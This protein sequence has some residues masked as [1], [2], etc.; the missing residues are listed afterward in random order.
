MTTMRRGWLHLAAGAGFGRVFG[1]F[2]N[3]LLSRWLGPIDLGLFNL[4]TTTVQNTDTLVRL[5]ADYA[6]NFELG[7]KSEATLTRRFAQL[8][9]AFVQ[10]CSLMTVVLC[11]GAAI[12]VL[13]AQGLFPNPS[14]NNHRLILG[15]LLLLM[16]GLECVAVSAWE[17][18][19]VSHKTSLL[20]LRQG[21]FFPLRLL[22]A[23]LG[24]FS[25]G[26]TG[27]MIGWISISTI[28]YLWLR[29]VL[30][31][32]W[33]PLHLTPILS[34]PISLLLKRGVP[35]YVANLLSSI[36][37]YPLL[38][39]V[40][41]SSG[42]A[43]IGYLRIGQIVQQLFA[44]LPATLVPVLFLRL[45][46][47]SSVIDQ[48]SAIERPFRIVWL[49]LLEVLLLYC[50]LD[51]LIIG[52]LFGP[53]F[54]AAVLPT[55]LLLLTALFEAVTQIVVQPLLAAGKTRLYGFWQNGAAIL[56][57]VI[58]WMWIPEAG[59]S[60][61][62]IVRMIYVTVPLIGFGTTVVKLLSEPRKILPLTAVTVSLLSLSLFQI[63][64]V[65]T[66]ASAPFLY[67]S[68]SALLAFL[69]REDLFYV[70][71]ALLNRT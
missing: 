45:R 64:E 62:L 26:V 36:I 67:F 54:T 24:S 22:F 41:A 3:L 2:C 34:R 23:S 31:G 4:V 1:F 19:L 5:G 40:A 17:I 44:F 66:L 53:D 29:R 25:F 51:R 35:F 68:T 33:H 32:L 9:R 38:L 42:L 10:I 61:Y 60:A 12:W 14:Q 57:A 37:F 63:F 46:A 47:E 58:G 16:I 13:W 20:S 50:S 69:R 56:A 71:R 28:Q 27:A 59:L 43:E 39:K 18:L 11:S 21:L 7:G 15:L 52:L 6:L 49:L 48:V 30:G 8:V 70:Q 65:Q 55:R